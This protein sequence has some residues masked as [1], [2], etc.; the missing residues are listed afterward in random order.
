MDELNELPQGWKWVKLGDVVKQHKGSIKRGPFGSALKKDFFKPS[1][2]KVYEQKHAIKNDFNIGSYYIDETKFNDLIDFELKSGDILISCSGTIGKIA[3]VPENIQR[4]V[5]NQA[6]L[7][8]TLDK[9]TI[10]SKYFVLFFESEILGTVLDGVQGSAIKNIA[11]VGELK[12][13]S[14]LLPPL[15]EQQRLATLLTAKLAL[16]EQAKEKITAQLQAAQALTAAYLREVFESE[17]AKGWEWVK[18]GDVCDITSSRRIFEN[19]YVKNG[20]PFF[21]TKEIVEL[22]QGK[23]IS[24][25]IFISNE[26]YQSIKK[27]NHVP[28]KGDLLISAVGT[29]GIVYIIPDNSEFY[30]KDG[31]LIWMRELTGIDC[32]YAKFVLDNYFKF[33]NNL[34]NGSTYNALTIIKLKEVEIPLPPPDKQKQLANYLSEKLAT[35]EQLKAALQTQLDSINQLPAALL[36]QAFKGEL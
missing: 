22:N 17:E 34:T 30:F 28:K 33:L 27:N 31:N 8:I 11:S 1:G 18:F 5:I 6:L 14:F 36:K 21:R 10:D 2:Y 9:N 25:E 13:I 12:K 19:E 20:I 35:V 7:K 15:P 26:K 29:I 4:G 32:F 3:I 16:I 23:N 24:V